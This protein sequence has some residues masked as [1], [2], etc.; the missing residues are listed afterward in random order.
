MRDFLASKLQPPWGRTGLVARRSL[1]ERLMSTEAPVIAVVAPPGYGKT[2][3]LSQLQ[4]Q[5]PL[6]TAWVS[7]DELD[8]DPA[9]LFTYLAR[10]LEQI[11]PDGSD[12]PAR[13]FL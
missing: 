13:S 8:N 9:V 11:E 7:L 4:Q 10:A 12:G 1:V 3:V 6:R 2:T 5:S